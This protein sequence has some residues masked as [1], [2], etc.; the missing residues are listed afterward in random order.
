[1]SK[2][3]VSSR[4]SAVTVYRDRAMITREAKLTLKPGEHSIVFSGLPANLDKNSL[5]VGSS[6]DAVL[7]ACM[8]ETEFFT[9]DVNEQ[10]S[11]LLKKQQ[12]L[13]DQ[14]LVLELQLHRLDGE[15]AFIEKIANCVT[16]PQ[17]LDKESGS[18]GSSSP[19]YLNVSL[20]ENLTGF[21][22]N[23]HSS[24]DSEKLESNRQIRT[25]QK[26][27]EK[28]SAELKKLGHRKSRSRDIVRVN[29][30]KQTEGE[31]VL[32]L[33]YAV[34]GPSWK[35]V[36]NLRFSSESDRL[37]FEYDAMVSQATGENWDNIDLKLST[38]RTSTSGTLP[39]LDPWRI[40]FLRP[41]AP[42]SLRS[43]MPKRKLA[44][45]KDELL[46]MAAPMA[47]PE[48][49]L[50][51]AAI[52]EA[53]VEQA[54]AS[55]LFRVSGATGI[56]GNNN[57]TRVGISRMEFPAEYFY[58][59]VPKLSQFAYRTAR[60]T[61]SSDFPILPGR[62]NIYH[63]GS[64]I[65]NSAFKLIMPE[66]KSDV[67]LGVDEGLKVEYR[68]LK[69]FRKNE[70]LINK[71]TSMQFMY[72]INIENNTNS[73]VDLEVF[74][75]F[76]ISQDKEIEVKLILPETGR[77]DEQVSLDDES[78]ITW[79]LSLASGEKLELPLT[80]LVEYPVDRLLT[81]L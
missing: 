38:A 25:I 6:E 60:F 43:N 66:Q 2:T 71:R 34:P 53:S 46:G 12:D 65:S 69:K 32:N 41:P 47:E 51:A 11:L 44:R 9:E 77:N 57:E 58:R 36:Y 8:F 21:Y 67:S 3:E 74:D 72:C 17:R 1:M 80:Y 75:Q 63:D 15:K 30:E 59:S 55:V 73:E 19:D 45:P 79:N 22:R 52:R 78:K 10:A 13:T 7:G 54:G 37:L 56:A 27:L 20:W 48:E 61:N 23:R 4:V 49:E 40:N 31:I 24:V 50:V 18:K 76:P 81:G 42:A 35:P 33:S 14:L 26:E 62:A 29:I 64:M 5:Q 70:G 28:L 16:S 39:E 68:F